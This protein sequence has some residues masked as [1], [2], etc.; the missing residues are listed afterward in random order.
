MPAEPVRASGVVRFGVFEAD[1]SAG[2]LRRDGRKVKLQDRPFEILVILLERPFEIITREEFRRRLWPAD[3]FVDFDHSLNASINK[4]RQALDDAAGNPRFVETAGRR[5]Y[6]FIAPVHRPDVVNA[7]SGLAP[8]AAE[9]VA[10][11]SQPVG[12][13]AAAALPPAAS[14][15]IPSTPHTPHRGLRALM[16]GAAIAG[17]A[18]LAAW[19][20][21]ARLSRPAQVLTSRDSILVAEFDNKTGDPVF[22]DTLKQALAIQLEQS[23]FLNLV[24][25]ERVREVLGFMGRSPDTRLTAGLALEM[26]QREAIKALLA[27]SIASLGRQYVISLNAVNCRDGASLVREQ[28]EAGSKEQVLHVLGAAAADLRGRLG[29]TLASIQKFDAPIEEATTPSLEAMKAFTLAGDRRAKGQE[30]E[31]I[32]FFERAIGLDPNFAMAHARLGTLYAN[33]DEVVRGSGYLRKAFEL[34]S[35]VSE[36]ERLYITARYFDVVEGDL[37]KSM[38]NYELWTEVYPKDWRPFNNLAVAC[39][40]I[41]CND[42]AESAARQ[43]L[44]LHPTHVFPHSNLAE[45]LMA[46]GRFDEAK[47]VGEE[48]IAAHFENVGLRVILYQ[49]AFTQGDAESM[50]RHVSWSR[51]K[52]RVGDMM[53]AEA[54]AAAAL[55]KLEEARQLF[56][57]AVSSAQTHGFAE[58]AATS[59]ALQALIEVELGRVDAGRVQARAAL[60]L[61]TGQAEQGTAAVAL[62]R[63]GEAPLA[64]QIAADLTKGFPANTVAAYIRIPLILAA[65]EIAGANPLRAIEMLR[66]PI[67]FEWGVDA[68]FVPSYLRGQAY[69]KAGSGADAAREFQDIIDRRGVNPTSPLISLARLGRARSFSA[70]GDPARSRQSY[71]ELLALWKDADPDLPV[72]QQARSEYARMAAR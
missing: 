64:R 58:N 43:A 1:L 35:R 12:V 69:L 37:E 39:L 25:D 49:I 46:L 51:D 42:K 4:L 47:R 32:P 14:P 62:A 68:D 26:C 65:V 24:P 19:L 54:Q 7:A 53:F 70:A 18:G 72:L 44:L 2:E 6:R 21:Y 11:A 60:R 67:P 41:G 22:D 23:P 5:G 56:A 15:S 33:I 38:Q 57:G 40:S 45:A 10:G 30:A 52:T 3:T 17:V 9:P 27:S 36:P 55:G 31:A 71:E 13:P 34:R 63:A 48:A 66:R 20:L 28:V 8:A 29:E 16:A 59:A 61:G 50:R